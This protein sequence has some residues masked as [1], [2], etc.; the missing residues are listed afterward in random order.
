MPPPPV[1]LFAETVAEGVTVEV[2]REG[3]SVLLHQGD[4]VVIG[5]EPLPKLALAARGRYRLGGLHRAI[6]TLGDAP[7]DR[8]EQLQVT[9][10]RVRGSIDACALRHGDTLD[11]ASTFG[12]LA[13]V[14]RVVVDDAPLPPPPLVA[15]DG[16]AA[17]E[18]SILGAVYGARREL[19]VDGSGR[20]KLLQHTDG[21][22]PKEATLLREGALAP[23]QVSALEDVVAWAR[24]DDLSEREWGATRRATVAFYGP[25]RVKFVDLVDTEV[26]GDKDPGA[27]LVLATLL[28][29]SRALGPRLLQWLPPQV[30]NRRRV[31]DDEGAKLLSFTHWQAG[32]HASS[33][34][35]RF[36][37]YESGAVIHCDMRLDERGCE[38]VG[39]QLE[40]RLRRP[41][42]ETVRRAL[43]SG[44]L[45]GGSAWS[46][47]E[48]ISSVYQSLSV[49]DR[50]VGG[51]TVRT[52]A[53]GHAGEALSTVMDELRAIAR[54]LDR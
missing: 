32:D 41:Q 3:Q 42:M 36:T 23:W 52:T 49:V 21:A 53:A 27:D 26:Q 46:N 15:R 25:R 51:K 16:V 47:P 5:A 2:V 37:V 11:V 1:R 24:V 18:S 30:P 20:V 8:G 4:H 48:H 54:E 39:A 38:R 34:G 50:F 33:S 40:A 6:V 19:V 10:D 35:Y 31:L 29:L 44:L 17:W 14:L 7:A 28:S 45:D 43:D 13:V 12:E 22:H 9:V